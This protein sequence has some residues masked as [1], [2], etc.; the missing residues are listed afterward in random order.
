MIIYLLNSN[1]RC[2]EM[3]DLTKDGPGGKFSAQEGCTSTGETDANSSK[4]SRRLVT[5]EILVHRT[6]L[7]CIRKLLNL[8]AL[9][10]HFT[11]SK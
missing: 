4:T 6:E 5:D 10:M 8:K 9:H 1:A 2:C 11:P 3:S 7:R